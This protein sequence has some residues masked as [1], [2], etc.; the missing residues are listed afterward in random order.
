MG[1]RQTARRRSARAIFAGVVAYLLA[2]QGYALAVSAAGLSKADHLVGCSAATLGV[3]AADVEV[4][5]DEGP[6]QGRR[7]HSECCAFC[8]ASGRDALL[9]LLPLA[10]VAIAVLAPVAKVFVLRPPRDN[11]AAKPV[12]W[13]SSWSSRAPP[14]FS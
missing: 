5:G 3:D 2:L 10:L 9:L 14:F 13:A 8:A 11:S 4:A 7:E 6:S 1:S 12:G